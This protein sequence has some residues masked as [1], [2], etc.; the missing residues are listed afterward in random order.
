MKE[1]LSMKGRLLFLCR[2]FGV[3]LCTLAAGLALFMSP[4]LWRIPVHHMR[5]GAFQRNFENVEHPDE[6]H[7]IAAHK[8]FGNF[9]NSNHCDYFV[10]EFRTSDLSREEIIRHYQ[11]QHIPP[12]DTSLGVWDGDPPVETEVEAYFLDEDVFRWWPW[13]EWLEE[14]LPRL[15]EDRRKTYLVFAMEDGYPP[16]GDIRCH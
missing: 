10:G 2:F 7:F 6:S 8:E 13:S 1:V 15:P 16:I 12:P 3:I 9:G 14:Y 4:W 11:G 5:L